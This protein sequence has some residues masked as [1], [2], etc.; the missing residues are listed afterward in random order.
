MLCAK[1]NGDTVE[2]VVVADEL[3]WC[4]DTHGGVWYDVTDHPRVSPK[5]TTPDNGVTWVEPTTEFKPPVP[6]FTMTG[7]KW[8]KTFSSTEWQWLKTQRQTNTE[9]DQL[10]DSIQAMPSIT[11]K[12]GGPLDDFYDWLLNNGLPG[13]QTRIDE[14]RAGY[15]P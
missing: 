4:I 2:W 1:M 8:I 6:E 5:W 3:Q 10:L 7:D 12:V 11:V 15:L 13:G 14:L 9:L